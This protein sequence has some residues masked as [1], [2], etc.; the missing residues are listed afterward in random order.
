MIEIIRVLVEQARR[1]SLAELGY[2]NVHTRTGN[3]YLGWPEQAPFGA[4]VVTAAAET[5]PQVL[6]DQLA[7]AGRA[8]VPAGRK[9]WE[10]M[11]FEKAPQGIIERRTIPVRFV[12]VT[13]EE[14]QPG[15]E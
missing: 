1:R 4:A 8:I 7:M 9:L 6:V 11:I 12:P 13:R 3:G 2:E 15:G 5:A 14:P 10:M